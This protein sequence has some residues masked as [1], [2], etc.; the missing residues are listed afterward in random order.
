MQW[1]PYINSTFCLASFRV[2]GAT[3][4]LSLFENRKLM[5]GTITIASLQK[6]AATWFFSSVYWHMSLDVADARASFYDFNFLF[7]EL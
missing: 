7:G 6:V 1:H 5:V 3:V 4:R 2:Q